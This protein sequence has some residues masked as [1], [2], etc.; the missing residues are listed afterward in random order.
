M[1]EE[2]EPVPDVVVLPVTGEL[3]LHAFAPKDVP[4]VVA[5]YLGAC[6]ERGIL[7]ARLV[8][9]KGRGVQ[10]ALVRRLLASHPQVDRFEEA[11]PEWGGWGVTLVT[12][13]KT[14]SRF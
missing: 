5:E 11:R 2:E 8:H 9:G 1:T 12:L 13:R 10:R 6:A 4:S 3:D 7:H 14:S